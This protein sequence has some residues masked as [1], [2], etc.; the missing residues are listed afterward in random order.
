MERSSAGRARLPTMT[1][2]TNSTETCCASVAYGPRPKASRRPPRRKRSDISRQASARHVASREKKPSM[3][4]LRMSRRSSIRAASLHAVSIAA[5]LTDARQRIADQHIYDPAAAVARG[6][7]HGAG[8]FGLHLANDDCILSAFS[9]IQRI[10]SGVCVFRCDHGKKLAFVGYVQRVE[11]KQLARAANLVAHRNL[12]FR[13]YDPKAAVASEFVE[14]SGN[15]S[16]SGIAHPA[17]SRSC[18]F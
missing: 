13:Q 2:C 18:F 7:E 10:Q 12:L 3:I 4:S 11:T 14:R 6:Y 1:G 16:T 5:S 17:D 9:P 15:P 8:G